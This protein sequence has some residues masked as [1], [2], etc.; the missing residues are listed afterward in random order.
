MLL[1]AI[2][3][4]V[5]FTAGFFLLEAV[6]FRKIKHKKIYCFF[7]ELAYFC[8]YWGFIFVKGI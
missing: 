5:T 7:V 4:S 6:F 8:L 1:K 3:I 2:I